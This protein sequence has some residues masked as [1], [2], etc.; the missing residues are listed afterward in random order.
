MNVIII[1]LPACQTPVDALSSNGSLPPTSKEAESAFV[2]GDSDDE[3][4]VPP[5][6]GEGE[7]PPAYDDV[8]KH[9]SYT[10]TVQEKE[11]EQQP[12][13]WPVPEKKA[14]EPNGE[15]SGDNIHYIRD[16]DTLLGIAFEYG[17]E[18]KNHLSPPHAQT[19]I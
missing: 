12:P 13:S 8:L 7:L 9:Q 14:E 15:N 11:E 10:L 1:I 17:I 3:D 4:A 5:A 16:N 18:V 2:L 6:I 19:C